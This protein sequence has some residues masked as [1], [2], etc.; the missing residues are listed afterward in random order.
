MKNCVKKNIT[1]DGQSVP[2]YF[3]VKGETIDVSDLIA[4]S[5]DK[6]KTFNHT[7]FIFGQYFNKVVNSTVSQADFDSTGVKIL[8]SNSALDPYFNIIKNYSNT[9]TK[10]DYD[11][12]LGIL[13][14]FKKIYEALDAE[15]HWMQIENFI[16]PLKGGGFVINLFDTTGKNILP[17]EAKR[18]PLKTSSTLGLGM[19][20]EPQDLAKL[21]SFSA[22]IN[23]KEVAFLEVCVASGMTTI[24]FLLDLHLRGVTPKR[25]KVITAAASIQGIELVKRVASQLDIEVEFFTAKLMEDVG[26]LY[27]VSQDSIIYTDGTFV[28]KSPEYAYHIVYGT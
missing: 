28:V 27:N 16:V 6:R 14:A 22:E 26:D 5:Y 10:L 23:G 21:D 7:F 25:V 19:N 20:L 1:L 18:V 8:P 4:D 15:F 11:S 2:L 13:T 24:G 17:V 9:D 12:A 3:P